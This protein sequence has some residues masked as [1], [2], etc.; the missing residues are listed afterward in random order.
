LTGAGAVLPGQWVLVIGTGGVALYAL[1]FAKLLGCRVA[2]VT[3]RGSKAGRLEDLGA[4]IVI[5]AGRTSE[6]G[7]LVFEQTG[8]VDLVVETGGPAT[9]AQ[10]LTACGLHGR[11]VLL[12]VQDSRGGSVEIPGD[13]YQ[14]SL[15]G[16]GRVFVGSRTS[17]EAMLRA[18]D[19][20]GV[21]PI[22]DRGFLFSEV[23]DAYRHFQRGDVFG[24][25]TIDIA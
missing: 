18:V 1:L 11:I 10:S 15:V 21:R 22:I 23:H 8:G 13:L 20:H 14:R 9:F 19:T 7:K 16:I 25:V 3:S 17:L 2:A 24:K 4:D 12:T 6:W 5:D